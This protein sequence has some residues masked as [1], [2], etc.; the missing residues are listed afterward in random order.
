MCLKH[1]TGSEAEASA[2]YGLQ[3]VSAV[4]CQGKRDPA[5]V[6]CR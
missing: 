2:I 1:I 6:N 4:N 3:G 5:A